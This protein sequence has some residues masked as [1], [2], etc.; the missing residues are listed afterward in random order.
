MR[1]LI[2]GLSAACQTKLAHIQPQTNSILCCTIPVP[3]NSWTRCSTKITAESMNCRNLNATW[4]FVIK[5]AYTPIPLCRQTLRATCD[6]SHTHIPNKLMSPLVKILQNSY[7]ARYQT[8][9]FPSWRHVKP[10]ITKLQSS[11]CFI[12]YHDWESTTIRQLWYY[13]PIKINFHQLS[14]KITRHQTTVSDNVLWM[15]F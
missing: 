10:R 6:H 8:T 1:N 2:S 12:L 15:S 5:R 13:K 9:L 11:V 7:Q 3:R 14:S 4:F